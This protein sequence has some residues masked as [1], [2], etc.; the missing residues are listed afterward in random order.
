MAGLPGSGKSTVALGLGQRLD[1]PVLD[2][3]IILTG[4][5]EG[6]LDGETSQAAAYRILF[7][8]TRSF[9]QDQRRSVII[10]S[11][12]AFGETFLVIRRIADDT[13]AILI[14]VLCLAD[15][16]VRNAR[17]AGRGA[18]PSQPV[19]QSRTAGTGRERF[20]HLPA[21]TVLALTERP[22]ATVLDEVAAAVAALHDEMP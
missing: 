18:L 4:L 2:K 11:P 3:D 8:L 20:R 7:G 12:L 6:G 10:D 1:S 15:R 17:V 14:P 22:L 5:I 19:R 9:V 21:T 16:D 13:G